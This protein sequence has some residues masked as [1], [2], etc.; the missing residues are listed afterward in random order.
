V[1]GNLQST[2]NLSHAQAAT[3]A[4]DVIVSGTGNDYVKAARALSIA[5]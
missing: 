3:T 2:A 1:R 4:I 5:T